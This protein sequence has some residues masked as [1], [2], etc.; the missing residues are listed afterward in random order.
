MGRVTAK[1]ILTSPTTWVTTPEVPGYPNIEIRSL[2]AFNMA[3]KAN[4]GVICG[5]TSK[6]HWYKEF[7]AIQQSKW[8]IFYWM[9]KGLDTVAQL[10]KSTIP[11]PKGTTVD[12][13]EAVILGTMWIINFAGTI[14]GSG[15]RR[16]FKSFRSTR[17]SAEVADGISST[18]NRREICLFVY[19]TAP[20]SPS[21]IFLCAGNYGQ[22]HQHINTIWKGSR[23]SQSS[24]RDSLS[25]VLRQTC[26]IRREVIPLK[27]WQQ[28]IF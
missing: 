6:A 8:R 23:F 16:L 20:C 24:K 2:D 26:H 9:I 4:P 7:E 25:G 19:L 5:E 10:S 15:D 14:H 18:L 21:Q 1:A 13:L 11:R 28:W 12:S 17:D 3:K 27:D 22:Y